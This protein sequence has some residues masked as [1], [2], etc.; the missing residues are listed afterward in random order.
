MFPSS[1][2]AAPRADACRPSL[3]ANAPLDGGNSE[4]ASGLAVDSGRLL[5]G[6][7][8]VIILHNGVPYRLQATRLGKLI[9]TK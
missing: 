4:P 6:H 5:Q 3:R 8:T 2:A 1:S 9:L 7:K